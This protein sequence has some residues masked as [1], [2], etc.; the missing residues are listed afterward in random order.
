MT[1]EIKVKIKEIIQRNYNVKSFRLEAPGVLD[2]QAGQFLSVKLQD[3]PA[4]KRYLSISSS[5]TEKG[6]L[7]F[8]KKLTGSDFSKTL[9]TLRTNDEVLIQYPFGKFVL[10]ESFPKIAFLSGGIGITPIRSICKYAVDKKL[11]SDIILIYAN[12]SVKDIVFKEDFDAMMKSYP[13]L[14]IAHV[15]T[16]SEPGFRCAVGRI[17][18]GL[19]KCEIP[20]YEKRKFYLCG[21]PPMVESM[22]K[23]LAEELSVP[24]EMIITENFQG[25]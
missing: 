24:P 9:D 19:I 10:D 11:G 21:P 16:E 20:D 17:N 6:Y 5:P 12:R 13:G 7:E 22:R 23:L 1:I 15:L 2:Y 8:T 4:L 18:A 3:N 14:K 25:Y